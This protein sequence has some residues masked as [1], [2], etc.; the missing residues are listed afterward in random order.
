MFVYPVINGVAY[1]RAILALEQTYLDLF[2][3]KQK[4]NIA[5]NA[6]GGRGPLSQKEKDAVSA[7]MRGV[8]V[9]RDPINKGVPLTPTLWNRML[10]GSVHRSYKVYVYDDMFN[11]MTMYPSIS[12]AVRIEKTQKNKFIAH[13]KNGTL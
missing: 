12:E 4:Y 9:G 2:P 5:L 1:V 8:N 6:S 13:I 3:V 10:D 7:W 11:L